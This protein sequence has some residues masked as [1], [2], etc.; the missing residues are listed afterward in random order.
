[1][2]SGVKKQQQERERYER[3]FSSA[4]NKEL[5]LNITKRVRAGAGTVL[6]FETKIQ[7]CGV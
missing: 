5:E 2:D 3:L 7:G 4:E 1:M 6:T